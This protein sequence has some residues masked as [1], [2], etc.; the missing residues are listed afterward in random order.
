[1]KK[2]FILSFFIL[3][4]C[5]S[6]NLEGL[7]GISMPEK[8]ITK[9]LP[10]VKTTIQ[11]AEAS[12]GHELDLVLE[13]EAV[14]VDS[15]K[16][17]QNGDSLSAIMDM[18]AHSKKYFYMNLLAFS[19]D[20]STEKMVQA[21][22]NKSRSNVD[23]RLIINKG[24]SL[25][26]GRC[27]KRLK[28][29]G[30]KVLKAKTHSSYFFNDD[31]ELMIG[32]Q[33]VAK[34]FFNS[35]GFNSLDRD[36]MIYSKG[37]LTAGA[38]KD[39]TS[40]WLEEDSIDE[41]LVK[42]YQ[43]ILKEIS[44]KRPDESLTCRFVAQRPKMGIRN[45]ESMLEKLISAS[46]IEIYFSGVKVDI[47][48]GSLG[49]GLKEIS[50][51]G[52]EVNYIG[53][54]YLSG[55]G[56]LTMV[57]DEWITGIKKGSFAFFSPVIEGINDWDKRRVARDNKK[58]YDKLLENSKINIW[59]YF[60]FIHYKVWLFDQSFFIGSANLDEDKFGDVYDAGIYCQ[61]SYVHDLLKAQLLRDKNNS[62]LY[63]G[64]K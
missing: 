24:F 26:S 49:R 27:L 25:L 35:D 33:C 30:I 40:I 51:K 23:V 52:V 32:S 48:E 5:T 45:I 14:K 29:A 62:V 18:I 3:V 12:L 36:M 22:E 21:L 8:G 58:L 61:N 17:Y 57:F 43:N 63:R 19:C 46:H 6:K 20:E 39:F 31:H 54:G 60:N 9:D 16:L 7:P 2:L 50:K 34:M 11:K 1:M 53:N 41:V 42:N 15:L 59:T 47:G 44:H 56:E 37:D 10:F 55:N 28:Q 4:S 13:N 64:Q 38:L